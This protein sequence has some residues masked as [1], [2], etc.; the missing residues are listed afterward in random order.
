M[1]QCVLL[2]T[3]DGLVSLPEEPRR[4]TAHHGN[5][6]QGVAVSSPPTL[7]GA[8]RDADAGAGL[9]DGA[10]LL[11][12]LRQTV[13]HVPELGACRGHVLFSPG[14]APALAV[15][16]PSTPR[17]VSTSS[18]SPNLD[19]LRD[20]SC[21]FVV[22]GA[23]NPA[24]NG[25]FVQ[26]APRSDGE[27]SFRRVSAA[28]GPTVTVDRFNGM[29]YMCKE[30]EIGS[31]HYATRQMQRGVNYP[32][33]PPTGPWRVCPNPRD[34]RSGFSFGSS[35]P[36]STEWRVARGPAPRLIYPGACPSGHAL[37]QFTY[38][39]TGRNTCE[40][41]ESDKEAN[42][43][44]FGCRRCD[45][46]VC[47]DCFRS[48][49]ACLR[50]TAEAQRQPSCPQP[51]GESTPMVEG[52]RVLCDSAS[53]VAIGAE[54]NGAAPSGAVI[55]LLERAE[56]MADLRSWLAQ[57]TG[58]HISA[59]VVPQRVCSKACAASA[60]WRSDLADAALGRSVVVIS[61]Q[62]AAQLRWALAQRSGV[63][64]TALVC[65]PPA[66]RGGSSVSEEPVRAV[67][68][69]LQ[70]L[71]A[72]PSMEDL[73]MGEDPTPTNRIPWAVATLV[74]L[75]GER[76]GPVASAAAAQLG[77]LSSWPREDA[78]A[79][80]TEG[81]VKPQNIESSSE[82]RAQAA[83]CLFDGRKSTY[84]ES[85]LRGGT[86]PHWV[87][88]NGWEGRLTE[89]SI[90][91]KDHD[92]YSPRRLRVKVKRLAGSRSGAIW[93]AT[94]AG[95][96]ELPR[97][98]SSMWH[99][100]LR[101][102]ELKDVVAIKL[103]VHAN[104][105]NG[106]DCRINALR[107][108]ARAERSGS[109]AVPHHWHSLSSAESLG[110]VQ[111]ALCRH[112]LGDEDATCRLGRMMA[113][114]GT[115]RAAYVLLLNY[116]ASL[117][118]AP[119]SAKLERA[120]RGA[121]WRHGE[122]AQRQRLKAESR[123]RPPPRRPSGLVAA[124]AA[125]E[126]QL[127]A[128]SMR[129]SAHE[130]G[131]GGSDRA[132][133]PFLL[134]QSLAETSIENENAGG[135]GRG[136][137]DPEVQAPLAQLR[138]VLLRS[139]LLQLFV[140]TMG[141]LP[142]GPARVRIRVAASAQGGGT[143]AS[144]LDV[145]CA[146][147]AGLA[148]HLGAALGG[149][150]RSRGG[151]GAEFA[152]SLLLAASSS[153][154]PLRQEGYWP[155]LQ[156][157]ATVTDASQLAALDLLTMHDGAAEPFA[158]AQRK[159]RPLSKESPLCRSSTS[160]YYFTLPRSIGRVARE[161][162]AHER[163]ARRALADSSRCSFARLVADSG[164]PQRFDSTLRFEGD[165]Q[166]RL[167]AA[168]HLFE[169][170][171]CLLVQSSHWVA[172]EL[173]LDSSLA[174]SALACFDDIAGR[175]GG[176]PV[177]LLH[178]LLLTSGPITARRLCEYS[179]ATP[180]GAERMTALAQCLLLGELPSL[181]QASVHAPA[182]R[183]N[184]RPAPPALV[185]NG[186]LQCPASFELAEPRALS[187]AVSAS[188]GARAA[189]ARVRASAE[190]S[191]IFHFGAWLLM[192]CT[193]GTGEGAS[194]S[195]Q[196]TH[197]T[198]ELLCA[199]LGCSASL[200]QVVPALTGAAD[201]L[202]ALDCLHEALRACPS[203]CD[204]G[205]R[206]VLS[207][208]FSQLPAPPCGPSSL[209]MLPAQSSR[210]QAQAAP[211]LRL[212]ATIGTDG[213]LATALAPTEWISAGSA[214]ALLHSLS[215]RS[216][217]P[218]EVMTVALM[219][220]RKL[221]AVTVRLEGCSGERGRSCNG[222]YHRL[223]DL[224]N[225]APQYKKEGGPQLIYF[226][227]ERQLWKISAT[228]STNGWAY[229]NS[230]KLL[231][232]QWAGAYSTAD[233]LP[234]LYELGAGQTASSAS[235]AASAASASFAS[236]PPA[237]PR[238][239]AAPAVD[240][241][242][243]TRE[244]DGELARLLESLAKSKGMAARDLSSESLARAVAQQGRFARLQA[245]PID[246]L[247]AR[248]QV[249]CELNE[250]CFEFLLPWLALDRAGTPGTLAHELASVKELLF[251]EQK[252]LFFE[253]IVGA[254][255]TSHAQLTFRFD[256]QAARRAVATAVGAGDE[257]L[258][259]DDASMFEQLL[260]QIATAG[261]RRR[262]SPR[263]AW[264]EPLPFMVLANH[265]K[266]FNVE[267]A[268]E[269]ASDVGGPYR[270]V[271]EDIC[272]ELHSAAL[273]LLVLTPNHSQPL[274]LDRGKRMLS[275]AASG[276]WALQ[277]LEAV[278]ALIGVTLRTGSTLPFELAN[279]VWLALLGE[280][281]SLQAYAK[282][283]KSFT[284]LVTQVRDNSHPSCP[285][286]DPEAFDAVYDCITFAMHR[287][288]GGSTVELKPGGA[289]LSLTYHN[290]SEWCSLATAFRLHECDAQTAAVRRGVAQILP[291]EALVLYTADELER[292]VCGQRDW[293]V[294]HLRKY[295]E[296]RTADSRSVGFLWEVLAEMVREEREL[297]LIFVWGRSRMPEGAP[298]QRFIVDSQHVQGD[299]DEHLPLAATCFFQLH[300]P[301]YRSKEACR[302][303]LLYAIY[304]CKEMDLA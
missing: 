167:P 27:V 175:A 200:S 37:A 119:V 254:T 48:A 295:A 280:A 163:R 35:A 133:P 277:R 79:S 150:Q 258:E 94:R 213:P 271:M 261:G 231:S 70:R 142:S 62:S 281:P 113:N 166:M 262:R 161:Q 143:V 248:C 182:E 26:A 6:V 60:R 136:G 188:G 236:S 264:D 193:S 145:K 250:R 198:F 229:T 247:H 299:P 139:S 222:T 120:C 124:A 7:A 39:S 82:T 126:R 123:P 152:A 171:R 77:A 282:V 192:R 296:V 55:A 64:S 40:V 66:R 19:R 96:V 63:W 228:G 16:A 180:D 160:Y 61:D 1:E 243:W 158:N 141:A 283:D 3:A 273:P 202:A 22:F 195:F 252:K 286:M 232:G 186:A 284:E 204:A 259:A 101:G 297:F 140:A 212:L 230:S 207:L 184:E 266:A 275:P 153:Y 146:A 185:A 211:L 54:G 224:H 191:S 241:P 183:L 292:L 253:R 42:T 251:N 12:G 53:L 249:L 173:V 68:E 144:Q 18:T 147:R 128:A 279:V 189:G 109:A 75:L 33:R 107:L 83:S 5:G 233:G 302:A 131:R 226:D 78:E 88:F 176:H 41:C 301:R 210:L 71:A 240:T 178:R 51:A 205:G 219:E 102:D 132:P 56:Q 196:L 220:H 122:S 8:L 291:L 43:V 157:A 23:G 242:D 98:R 76:L 28:G 67:G 15:R 267:F 52:L 151:G 208:R 13:L 235:S 206:G 105:Q 199:L 91:L 73:G 10:G 135:V 137:P 260:Q 179:L 181:S 87:A 129:G 121:E 80:E 50:P 110:D 246:A 47:E 25:E 103:E 268:G 36:V 190:V 111:Q 169:H 125:A 272:A 93:V 278:G 225:D 227:S 164:S 85:D 276:A 46:D 168:Q 215:S 187:S 90:Y 127:A 159:A 32:D 203:A 29:W 116:L 115:Q 304:N 74:R 223:P 174:P 9:E 117:P 14:F 156:P 170:L 197:A 201:C 34:S 45:W 288:D 265:E 274:A 214:A 106:I 294:E 112:A 81:E 270:H 290:R 20:A 21:A 269:I 234:L 97:P 209:M 100:L 221:A 263:E 177:D 287:S 108:I 38:P 11:D 155:G 134:P 238:A 162:F 69:M 99:P 216:P 65:P 148:E 86:K 4:S 130:A 95:S 57:A 138:H 300:L 255:A 49:V 172:A 303:K 118:T 218:S 30:H 24:F 58:A 17:R 245:I 237:P 194:T 89:L 257:E 165:A 154:G 239:G 31:W 217:L 285:D 2:Q 92:S 256:R 293:S 114:E 298:P 149:G 72:E 59:V 289:S 244:Q 84:W 44:A 104:H